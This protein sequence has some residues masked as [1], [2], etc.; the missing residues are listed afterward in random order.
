MF[1]D[2]S[3]LMCSLLFLFISI[4]CLILDKKANNCENPTQETLLILDTPTS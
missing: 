4:H 2:K 3:K 1:T